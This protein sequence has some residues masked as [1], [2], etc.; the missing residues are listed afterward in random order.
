MIFSI[1]SRK[2]V[3]SMKPEGIC[4][5]RK[6]IFSNDQT[7]MMHSANNRYLAAL[8]TLILCCLTACHSDPQE[9]KPHYLGQTMATQS[10]EI[11]VNS[12]NAT[13]QMAQN[14]FSPKNAGST[15]KF[16]IL[17]VTLK[18]IGTKSKKF[19]AGDLIIQADQTNKFEQFEP[20]LATDYIRFESMIPGQVQTGNIAYR[21]PSA[22]E[23]KLSWMPGKSGQSIYLIPEPQTSRTG[24]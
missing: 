1:Q 3:L 4:C 20:T 8:L 19:I 5:L 14:I 2:K 15:E 21:V 18:N 7:K 9:Q 24:Q 10:F 13:E 6:W 16:I 12:V 17:N 11:T 23:G 22:L